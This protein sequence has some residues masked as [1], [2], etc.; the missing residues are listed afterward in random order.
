LVALYRAN[1]LP[2]HLERALENGLSR[3]ELVEVIT[4]LAFHS[5]WPTAATAARIAQRVFEEYEA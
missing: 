1:E 4:H 3:E 5:G 2:F